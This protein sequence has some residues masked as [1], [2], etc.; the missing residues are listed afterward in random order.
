MTDDDVPKVIVNTPLRQVNVVLDLHQNSASGGRL[1]LA[2]ATKCPGRA[3]ELLMGCFTEIRLWQAPCRRLR[4]SLWHKSKWTC[5]AVIQSVTV[6]WH[7]L[8]G[9]C[10]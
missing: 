3:Q 2:V 6:L 5:T 1:S 4:A 9:V 7:V 8:V 10:I